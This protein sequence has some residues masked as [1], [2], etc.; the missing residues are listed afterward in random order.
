[1][2][3]VGMGPEKKKKISSYQRVFFKS[4]SPF[5]SLY[6]LYMWPASV[7][8]T[9]VDNNLLNREGRS[10]SRLEMT[11]TR[12]NT[13]KQ[14]RLDKINDT[15]KDLKDAAVQCRPRGVSLNQIPK[16]D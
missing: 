10:V 9:N 4:S 6:P 16:R 13:R 8:H 15:I 7:V 5:K 1:M 2:P 12:S 3:S 14:P 11:R